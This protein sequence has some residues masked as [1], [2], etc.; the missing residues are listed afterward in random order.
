MKN[1]IEEDIKILEGI[2]KGDEDCINAIYSQMKVKNDNDEDIQY[3]KKEIQ[4]IKN[5]VD[6]YLKEKARADKLEK[7]YSAMLTE[8][9]ENECD[10]KRVLKENEELRQER[11]LVGLPVRNKRSGKIGIILHQWESGSI[12]VLENIR[13]RV[14]NTHD[15][16]NTLEI[17][18]GNV[19]QKRKETDCI[20]VQ[21]V[22]D[23]IEELKKNLYTVEH[24]ETVGAINVLQELLEGRK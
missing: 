9:D 3:Y 2:I 17:I 19:K 5:I 22:K 21:K 10:Y 12:A 1:S 24:Y 16:W 20:P 8:S 14:I 15:N 7:E 4:S 23:T 6:N 18:N 11:E 13:P